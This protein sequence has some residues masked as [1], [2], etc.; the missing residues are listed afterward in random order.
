MEQITPKAFGIND[1][2]RA[3]NYGTKGL[4]DS[5]DAE[6]AGP[7]DISVKAII[8]R[9][10]GIEAPYIATKKAVRRAFFS[11]DENLRTRRTELMADYAH[12]IKAKD[13]SARLA[14]IDAIKRFNHTNRGYPIK[15]ADIE[16]SLRNRREQEHVLARYGV[17]ATKPGQRKLLETIQARY[18]T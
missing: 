9:G 8:E 12:A 16:S 18:G 14:A 4:T 13:K 2:M 6:Y 1:I 11:R 17:R 10:L 7:K 5:T 15:R 3:F